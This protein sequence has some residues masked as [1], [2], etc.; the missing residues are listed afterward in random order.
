MSRS[1]GIETQRLCI[2]PG[3]GFGKNLAHNLN[4]LRDLEAIRV[5]DLPILVG[6][7][8]KRMIGDLTGRGPDQRLI[9]SVA[10]ALLAV[11]RGADIVRVHDVAATVDALKMLA[12]VA[13][14]NRQ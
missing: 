12:A 8:R 2:D 6:L 3:F 9:G 10:G 13:A 7:S 14:D 1:A 11:Q 4:L 5:D